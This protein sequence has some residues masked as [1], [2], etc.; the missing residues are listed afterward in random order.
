MRSYPETRTL[1]IQS[2]FSTSLEHRLHTWIGESYS[3]T[4]S[5]SSKIRG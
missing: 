1:Q 5:G 3:E 2:H 4:V